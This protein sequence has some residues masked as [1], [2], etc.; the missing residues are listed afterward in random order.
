M[1]GIEC[2]GWRRYFAGSR[3]GLRQVQT[4]PLSPAPQGVPR[5]IPYRKLLL[6]LPEELRVLFVVAYHVGL[7]KGALL[8]IKWTQVDVEAS[9]IW[10]EGKKVNRKPGP[11][12]VPI[13]GDMTELLGLTQQ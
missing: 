11:V 4:P 12:A 10:M 3:V 9:R 13:C 5:S 7:R 6:A 8:R 2:L 1:P